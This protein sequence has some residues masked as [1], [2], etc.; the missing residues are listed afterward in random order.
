MCFK[1]I[2]YAFQKVHTWSSYCT[3]TYVPY[4][5]IHIRSYITII[6]HTVY[7]LI[8]Y[9]HDI[10]IIP[11]SSCLKTMLLGISIIGVMLPNTKV[12]SLDMLLVTDG[13]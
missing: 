12:A 4:V 8:L 11:S 2:K 5:C 9:T 7:V 6:V 13:N 10:R 1:F 3:C